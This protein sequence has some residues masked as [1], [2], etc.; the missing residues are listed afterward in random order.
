M[1][2]FTGRLDLDLLAGEGPLEEMRRRSE[3]KGRCDAAGNRVS[4]APWGMQLAHHASGVEGGMAGSVWPVVRT[5]GLQAVTKDMFRFL[6]RRRS[7]LLADDGSQDAALPVSMVYVE[8][9]YSAGQ[10]CEQWRAEGFAQPVGLG[11][12]LETAPASSLAQIVAT[13][14]A[15]TSPS[16][17]QGRTLLGDPQGFAEATAELKKTLAARTAVGGEHALAR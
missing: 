9:S 15:A 12:V 5:I 8:G 16:T 13:A 4:G 7:P 3:A 11:S 10:V 2:P 6:L 17:S 1:P 14:E